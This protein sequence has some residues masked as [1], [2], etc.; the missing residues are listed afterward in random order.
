MV[1]DA[2]LGVFGLSWPSH[3]YGLI[4]EK[5]GQI[6][7]GGRLLLVTD[8]PVTITEF[9]PVSL[10]CNKL[11]G[12]HTGVEAM[13]PSQPQ[14]LPVRRDLSVTCPVHISHHHRVLKVDALLA[15]ARVLGLD[16]RSKTKQTVVAIP[17]V[18]L[19]VDEK[20]VARSTRP[21][22]PDISRRFIDGVEDGLPAVDL[23]AA[24]PECPMLADGFARGGDGDPEPYWFLKIYAATFDIDPGETAHTLSSGDSR[25]TVEETDRKLETTTQQQSEKN[26]G[27][28]ACATFAQ[29]APHCATCHHRN[30][31]K[32]PLHFA[33]ARMKG[34]VLPTMQGEK[35]AHRRAADQ[36]YKEARTVFSTYFSTRIGAVKMLAHLVDADPAIASTTVGR[37]VYFVISRLPTA[38]VADMLPVIAAASD[39]ILGAGAG[40]ALVGKAI[41]KVYPSRND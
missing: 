31:G 11:T 20:P 22:R 35:Y 14:G 25:Y 29:Y 33:A 28:P 40:N 8:R 16:R 13:K 17:T 10:V 23:R 30:E 34:Y 1:D 3:S 5:T 21:M 19:D 12:E 41:R 32:S 38:V 9:L 7:R 27:W 24:I 18:L 26:L 2:R 15:H 36:L 37:A 39:R 4:S 6:K